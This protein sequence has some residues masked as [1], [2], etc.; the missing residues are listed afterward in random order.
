MNRNSQIAKLT[1]G[2]V[3]VAALLA[4]AIGPLG[5]ANG[6]PTPS[7]GLSAA[8]ADRAALEA[9]FGGP[10]P[11]GSCTSSTIIDRPAVD[12]DE[13]DRRV[14]AAGGLGHD[15]EGGAFAGPLLQLASVRL[16]RVV[17]VSGTH[18]WI[19]RLRNGAASVDEYRLQQSRLGT[20]IWILVGLSGVCPSESIAPS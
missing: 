5:L 9:V 15:V 14:A 12:P 7:E 19:S 17:A 13:W 20:P 6:I 16:G 4:V 18:A 11:E 8:T 3:G 1:L 10:V 2:G